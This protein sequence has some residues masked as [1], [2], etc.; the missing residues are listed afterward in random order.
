MVRRAGDST[1][2]VRETVRLAIKRRA[3]LARH[4]NHPRGHRHAFSQD[5]GTERILRDVNT[6][7]ALR[8]SAPQMRHTRYILQC[9]EPA[10]GDCEIDASLR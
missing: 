8:Q 1:H 6:V 10:A 5:G 3:I 2:L 4:V 7:D 9:F